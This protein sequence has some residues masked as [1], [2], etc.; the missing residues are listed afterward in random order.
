MGLGVAG[1]TGGNELLETLLHTESVHVEGNKVVRRTQD[2]GVESLLNCYPFINLYV[3]KEIENPFSTV[4]ADDRSSVQ[5][6]DSWWS[7]LMSA[8]PTGSFSLRPSFE[9][10]EA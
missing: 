2:G 4:N 7:M 8:S 3:G 9:E 10:K 1:S 6:H 5:Q